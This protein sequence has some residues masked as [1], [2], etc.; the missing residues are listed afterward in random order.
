MLKYA[1]WDDRIIVK[2]A[3]GT[4]PFQ[5]WGMDFIG[6]INPSSSGQHRW[7]LTA[8]EFFTKW[9]EAIPTRNAIDKVIM[10]CRRLDSTMLL[11]HSW[12]AGGWIPLRCGVGDNYDPCDRIH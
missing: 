11:P 7:I 12:D 6:E 8:I 1:L 9:V 3:I 4:S 2:Q 5:Q 10:E